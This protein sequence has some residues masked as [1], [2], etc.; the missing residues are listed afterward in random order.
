MRTAGIALPEQE[1]LA[2]YEKYLDVAAREKDPLPVPFLLD[3]LFYVPENI[4]RLREEL[5]GAE[6]RQ[7]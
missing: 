5:A 3:Y 1:A 7:P 2:A 6:E 4:R